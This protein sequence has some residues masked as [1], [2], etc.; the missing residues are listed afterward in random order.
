MAN[1]P[2]MV[3]ACILADVTSQESAVSISKGQ[4]LELLAYITELEREVKIHKMNMSL[5]ED[6]FESAMI[7][8]SRKIK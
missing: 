4:A 8:A 7:M 5:L 3:I 2:E 6:D 1:K